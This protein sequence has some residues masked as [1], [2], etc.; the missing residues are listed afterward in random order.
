MVRYRYH[1]TITPGRFNDALKWTRAMN[2]D[3][4]KNGWVEF[5]IM[6]PGFGP[7]N[8]MILESEYADLAA[9]DKEQNEFYQN[10]DAMATFR[11]GIDL[12]AHGTHPWDEIEILVEQD[13]A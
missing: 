5:Q 6:A 2:A 7:I 1:V 4:K 3:A 9:Y 11:S 12:S 10:A 13:L 8:Q